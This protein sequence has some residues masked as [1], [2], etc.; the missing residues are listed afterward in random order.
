MA[1]RLMDRQNSNCENGRVT[2][3]E[4]QIQDNPR[5]NPH[6]LLHKKIEEEKKKTKNKPKFHTE[7]Q[8]I[9]NS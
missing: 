1:L 8:M 7:A 9:P 2:K 4:L 3:R 6:N 5:Q